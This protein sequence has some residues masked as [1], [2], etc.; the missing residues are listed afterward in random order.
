MLDCF[1]LRHSDQRTVA[2][3]LAL[4]ALLCWHTAIETPESLQPKQYKFRI[5]LNTATYGELQTLPGIGPKL[6]ENIIQYRDGHAPNHDFGDIIS[7]SGI[8]S[9][10]H[11]TMKPYFT[12]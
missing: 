1:Q 9:K 6:A 7:V 2:V 3:L 8:G 11:T 5:D 12:D 10:R 4:S